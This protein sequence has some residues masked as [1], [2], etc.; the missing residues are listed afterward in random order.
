MMEN[1]VL[2]NFSGHDHKNDYGGSYHKNG[3][4]IELQ[5][6]RKTGYGSYGPVTGVNRGATV[7]T[8]KSLGQVNDYNILKGR[9]SVDTYI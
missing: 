5:Y 1:D 3:K 8:L 6:G 2:A 4:Q 9:I 7:I